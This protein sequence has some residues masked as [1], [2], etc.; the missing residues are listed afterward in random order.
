MGQGQ[1][2]LPPAGAL[3]HNE[4]LLEL[5]EATWAAM[6]CDRATWKPGA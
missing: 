4:G 1:L 5:A 2:G 6:P 3:C